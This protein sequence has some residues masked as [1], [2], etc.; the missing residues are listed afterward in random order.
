MRQL[1]ANNVSTTLSS[2]LATNSTTL[3]VTSAAGF[4]IPAANQYFLVTVQS[5]ASIEVIQITGVNGA[6]FTISAR[7]QEGTV[8]QSF[9]SGSLCEMRITAGTLANLEAENTQLSALAALV[10]PVATTV[11][12]Y[13][14]QD[15]LDPSGNPLLLLAAA[16]YAWTPVNYA[17]LG[18]DSLAT[19]SSTTSFTTTVGG[20][21]LKPVSGTIYL[22]QLTTGAYAG[23]VKVVTAMTGTSLTVSPPFASV[24]GG[25]VNLQV[26]QYVGNFSQNLAPYQYNGTTGQNWTVVTG[27]VTLTASQSGQVIA[28]Y[29]SSPA[30]VTLPAPAVGLTYTILGNGSYNTLVSCSSGYFWLPDNSTSSTWS[31]TGWGTG[32]KVVADGVNWRAQPF[33]NSVALPATTNSGPVTYG[34][35]GQWF[36]SIVPGQTTQI[37]GGSGSAPGTVSFGGAP[38]G[39]VWIS[40]YYSD[41]PY[42]A[43]SQTFGHLLTFNGPS[44]SASPASGNATTQVFYGSGGTTYTRVNSNGTGWSSWLTVASVQQLQNNSTSLS[45]TTVNAS[46]NVSGAD[47]TGGQNY[48]T[49]NQ[50]VNGSFAPTYSS[51]TVNGTSTFSGALN[52]SA[53]GS[54][55]FTSS[56]LNQ[57][58]LIAGNYGT[59]LRNDA[60]SFYILATASG[61]PTGTFST[62]RPFAFNLSSGNVAIDGTGAGTTFGG[63]A[64]GSNATGGQNFLTWSQS[65]NGSFSPTYATVTASN[66]NVTGTVVAGQLSLPAGA[67]LNLGGGAAVY[68]DPNQGDVVLRSYNGSAYQYLVF[69]NSGSVYIPG[70]VQSASLGTGNITTTGSTYYNNGSTFFAKDTS[71]NFHNCFCP[72]DSSN[73]VTLINGAANHVRVVNQAYNAELW[74]CDNAGN[75]M[76]AGNV[77]AYSDERVKK[78]WAPLPDNTLE[79]VALLE[80]SGIYTRTDGDWDGVK[81]VG[82]GAQSL[83]KILPEAVLVDKDGKYSINY[84]S[85]ALVLCVELARKVIELE[86][87]LKALQ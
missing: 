19:M 43:N 22:A 16:D 76:S 58:R 17:L 3:I 20:N 75:T 35:L 87:Q 6:T 34:Q 62:L 27:N 50:S 14:V 78:D 4:P 68:S 70:N 85:A 72:L 15:T 7:G 86:K 9:P 46:G 33:G 71:G 48:L 37:Y 69:Y 53:G 11:D 80:K 66:V 23:Q 39:F 18:S 2:A 59:I 79:K 31:F 38:K 60:G 29:T 63:Q 32:I 61:S 26:Y 10:A 64:S 44:N 83:E 30:T 67:A 8:A 47:A 65:T 24:L 54:A 40:G 51:L 5:G 82:V 36:G 77:S 42:G 25:N 49:W 55:N 84:G 73:D 12:S 56:D 74:Y 28:A 41:S 21:L 13:A 57:I 45:P 81:Q 52:Y 1:F